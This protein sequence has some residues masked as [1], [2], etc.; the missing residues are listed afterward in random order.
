MQNSQ[1]VVVKK[2]AVA[3]ALIML[4]FAGCSATG[5]FASHSA[6]NQPNLPSGYQS[7]AGYGFQNAPAAQ[8][9][10][11]QSRQSAG[12]SGYGQASGSGLRSPF[13]GG[14]YNSGSC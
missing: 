3:V 4:A 8:F 13:V 12:A 1:S 10:G 14:N 2:S 9:G 7:P 6:F 11:S 5:P